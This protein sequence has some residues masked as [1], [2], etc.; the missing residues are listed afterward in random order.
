MYYSCSNLAGSEN[1]WNTLSAKLE[2]FYVSVHK[3]KSN[4]NKINQRDVLKLVSFST[5]CFFRLVMKIVE[6]ILLQHFFPISCLLLGFILPP[7][8]TQD[9]YWKKVDTQRFYYRGIKNWWGS[10]TSRC[11]SKNYWMWAKKFL[12]WLA[13]C[14]YKVDNALNDHDREIVKQD[15]A[16]EYTFLPLQ[17]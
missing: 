4:A 16:Y 10:F 15:H 8:N 13:D 7:Q 17:I 2:L 14:R 5:R 1:N 11:R 3:D 9:G 6:Q 12:P